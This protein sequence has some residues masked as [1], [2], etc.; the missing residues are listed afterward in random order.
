MPVLY[1]VTLAV[2][3]RTVPWLKLSGRGLGFMP[4][5]NIEMLRALA[6]D[7]HIIRDT[8]VDAIS[9]LVDL[10]DRAYDKVAA[11]PGPVLYLYGRKDE[12]VPPAPTAAAVAA[13]PD[14]GG[15][16]RVVWY[17]EGWHMLL[18]DL[19]GETVWNDILAWIG[20]PVARLPSGADRD[21]RARLRPDR[22]S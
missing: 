14:R 16:V 21:A 10:M 19:Q 20:D 4:S 18:R 17:A 22:T 2:A 9:G 12:I 8:R 6:R 5:D 11:V 1:R 7:P 3:D 15:R 13:L